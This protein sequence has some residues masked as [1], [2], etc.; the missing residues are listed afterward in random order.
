M[1]NYG[2]ASEG[3]LISGCICK[4]RNRLS[5]RDSDD[6]SFFNTNQVIEK[7][8]TQIFTWYRKQFFE[9]GVVYWLVYLLFTGIRRLR[10][11]HRVVGSPSSSRGSAG[12]L[13]AA[14]LRHTCP[15]DVAEGKRLLPS[16]LWFVMPRFIDVTSLARANEPQEMHMRLM[17]FPWV[18]Y[19]VLGRI[20]SEKTQAKDVS[21]FSISLPLYDRL[22]KHMQE[23]ALENE[24]DFMQTIEELRAV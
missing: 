9:V 24:E 18:V 10:G 19:D 7:N 21:E 5:D 20:K 13:A 1:E 22:D 4:I 12:G 14:N 16:C 2:I 8:V 17:S 15:G 6:M 11:M 23:Y 3:E